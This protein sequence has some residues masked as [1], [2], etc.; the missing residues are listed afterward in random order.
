MFSLKA[1]IDRLKEDTERF[2]NLQ[3]SKSVTAF[4]R[5]QFYTLELLKGDGAYEEKFQNGQSIYLDFG[6]NLFYLDSRNRFSASSMVL[7]KNCVRFAYFL[8]H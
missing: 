1:Q 2:A 4:S 3:K 5:I 8:H 6:K 7:L